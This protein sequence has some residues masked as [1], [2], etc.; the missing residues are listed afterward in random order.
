MKVQKCIAHDVTLP[1]SV[2][3]LT[4]CH[5]CQRSPA[6]HLIT[7]RARHGII[8]RLDELVEVAGNDHTLATCDPRYTPPYAPPVG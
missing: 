7:A 5:G 4:S 8:A 3:D 1:A 2:P 6:G